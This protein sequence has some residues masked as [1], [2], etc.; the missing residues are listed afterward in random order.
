MLKLKRSRRPSRRPKRH[1]RSLRSRTT[2]TATENCFVF[3]WNWLGGSRPYPVFRPCNNSRISHEKGCIF[4][5]EPLILT[6][7]PESPDSTPP[8][9][10]ALP[11]A[12]RQG[13]PVHPGGLPPAV[14]VE[15]EHG[16]DIRL[17][18]LNVVQLGRRVE[19]GWGHSP[20]D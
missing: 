20:G 15:N 6:L 5:E 17:E 18:R 19:L 7:H 10:H 11:S 16:P 3:R 2:E 1:C 4:T 13:P 8:I 9:D 12:N 14:S